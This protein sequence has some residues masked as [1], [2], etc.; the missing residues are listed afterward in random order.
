MFLRFWAYSVARFS[1]QTPLVAR[2]STSV[3][4]LRPVL[5][6]ATKALLS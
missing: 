2:E 3:S 4:A 1:S 6:F 5:R